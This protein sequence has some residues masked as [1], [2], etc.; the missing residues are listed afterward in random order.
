MTIPEDT[1]LHLIG[2]L[3]VAVALVALLELGSRAH[4]A[5][6]VAV[7]GP[8][9]AWGVERYQAIRRAGTPEKRDLIATA[10]PFEVVAAALWLLG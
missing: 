8:L 5:L 4:P 3:I 7:A 6:A 1:R 9:F 10:L 2:G